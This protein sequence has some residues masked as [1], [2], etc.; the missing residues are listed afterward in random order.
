MDSQEYCGKNLKATVRLK[1]SYLSL[2][3]KE[4]EQFSFVCAMSAVERLVVCF[5]DR[6]DTAMY[7]NHHFDTAYN[8]DLNSIS[9]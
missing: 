2:I 5:P 8:E 6:H 9:T 7:S 4:L 1:M 3:H